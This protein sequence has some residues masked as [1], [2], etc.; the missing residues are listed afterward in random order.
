MRAF[1]MRPKKC[2]KALEIFEQNKIFYCDLP[3]LYILVG[4][5][6]EEDKEYTIAVSYYQSALKIMKAGDYYD[7]SKIEMFSQHIHHLLK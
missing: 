5:L 1:I 7:K 4:N 3:D 2:I 6:Y